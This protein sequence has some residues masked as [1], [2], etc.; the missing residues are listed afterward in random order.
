MLEDD[1]VATAGNVGVLKPEF[2]TWE[3]ERERYLA[4]IDRI[5]SE[6]EKLRLERAVIEK[7]L[8]TSPWRGSEFLKVFAAGVILVPLVWFYVE[9]V[10]S[11]MLQTENIELGLENAKNRRELE[12]EREK[13]RESQR[14]AQSEKEYLEK[15][16]GQLKLQKE[17]LERETAS[18]QDARESL[19]WIGEYFARRLHT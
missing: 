8:K 16:K 4:E 7:E 10:V 11:P 2:S 3:L 9:K 12:E 19:Y 6:A 14:M 5:R 13:F 15:E 18:L 17:Q 1:Q